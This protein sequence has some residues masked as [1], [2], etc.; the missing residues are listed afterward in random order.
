MK[1]TTDEAIANKKIKKSSWKTAWSHSKFRI[2]TILGLIFMISIL[3]FFPGFLASI[4]LRDGIVLNDWFLKIL[5][6]Y[7]V[8][9]PIFIILYSISVLGFIRIYQ[10]A[11]I[12]IMAIWGFSLLFTA[13]IIT[14]AL[15]PLNTPNDFIMLVDP[16]SVVF[17]G[18]NTITK[19]LFF[20]GHT[21]TLFFSALCFEKKT[22]KIVTF[23]LT[24]IIGFLL[25]VQ[26]AHYT[27][28]IL[29]ALVFS[30]CCWYLAKKITKYKTKSSELF[31]IEMSGI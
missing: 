29:G 13:R 4:E 22:D 24:F 11:S 2:K 23:I 21:A 20:S 15:V 26:R 31:E 10:N 6:A 8:S 9:I 17:Y 28:D 12:G 7:D 16:A 1:T 3:I 30:Y 27:I 18:S 14:I 25:L 19:D 5:P